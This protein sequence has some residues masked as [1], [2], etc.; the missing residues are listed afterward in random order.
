MADFKPGL[1]QGTAA[2]YDRFRPPYPPAL[3]DELAERA[4][5][6]PSGRLADLACGTGHITFALHHRFAA[7]LAVDSEPEMTAFVRAKAEAA[8]IGTID[9]A[10]SAIEGL[11][12]PDASFDVIAMGNAFHRVRRE[13]VA[14][15]VRRW[16]RPDGHL[17]LLWGGSPWLGGELPWQQAMTSL[18]RRWRDRTGERVP[19]GYEEERRRRPDEVVLREAGL[20]LASRHE[21]P[22]DR[23]WTM[24]ELLGFMRGT[25]TH[26]AAAL[27]DAAAE[28]D[29]EFR[30]R[31]LAC[32]PSGRFRQQMRFALELFTHSA[33]SPAR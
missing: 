19:A 12:L 7:V 1:Y 33:P 3:F 32:E 11:A 9:C 29:A 2:D 13:A 30:R 6:G 31:M 26:S 16:L 25:S 20:H 22:V 27:G 17:A 5:A 21:F 24:P 10:T 8:G 15:R 4:V 28:F 23:E 14:E 18:M